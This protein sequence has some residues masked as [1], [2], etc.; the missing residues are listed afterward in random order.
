M[1]VICKRCTADGVVCDRRIG[2]IPSQWFIQHNGR[3]LLGRELAPPGDIASVRWEGT[4]RVL[5][6][7]DGLVEDENRPH[8]FK[9]S[10]HAR[11]NID[12][13]YAPRFHRNPWK[14]PGPEG[15]ALGARSPRHYPAWAECP[16][17]RVMRLLG[18]DVLDVVT[19]EEAGV[20]TLEQAG[21]ITLE[22]A[23]LR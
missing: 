17:C 15:R 14:L 6:L 18:R 23:G 7:V 11:K 21:V 4:E 13:G 8:H 12:H 1:K 3:H 10:T 20:I 22:Q 5:F 2:K 9:L 16:K 19:L